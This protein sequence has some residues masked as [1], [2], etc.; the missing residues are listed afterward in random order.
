M[1]IDDFYVENKKEINA[2]SKVKLNISK[3]LEKLL[4]SKPT[5]GH[6]EY[7]SII[8]LWRGKIIE[9]VFAVRT[10]RGKP[11]IQEVIRR[12]EGNKKIL[13]KNM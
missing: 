4:L 5:N 8:Q 7:Y 2:L 12:I 9:R 6:T 3:E 10:F 1:K 13:V 11:E